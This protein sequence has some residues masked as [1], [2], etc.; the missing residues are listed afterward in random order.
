MVHALHEPCGGLWRSAGRRAVATRSASRVLLGLR[1]DGPLDLVRVAEV[2]HGPFA[3][4]I[5]IQILDAAADDHAGCSGS[6][7]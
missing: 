1:Q 5:H 3:E 2:S 4:G 7:K 6:S